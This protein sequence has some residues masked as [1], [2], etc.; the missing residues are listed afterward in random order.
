MKS[1]YLKIFIL[2]L[3]IIGGLYNVG[4][5]VNDNLKYFK[6]INNLFWYPYQLFSILLFGYSLHQ[7][8]IK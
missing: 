7:I 5:A 8:L 6:Y 2:Y 4:F 1:K 3:P